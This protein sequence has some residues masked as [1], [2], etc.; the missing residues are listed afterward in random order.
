M[1]VRRVGSSSWVEANQLPSF[2][3]EAELERLLAS[4]P[5]LL[6]GRP[7]GIALVQQFHIPRVQGFFDLCGVTPDGSIYL[8]EC[9]LAGNPDMRRTIVG[10]LLAYAAGL[11][12]SSSEEFLS[13][14]ARAAGNSG[15]SWSSPQS[16]FELAPREERGE[17]DEPERLPE[18]LAENLKQGRFTLVFAVDRLT[19]ELGL[20]VD[21]LEAQMP[22]VRVC[23]LEMRYGQHENTEVLTPTLRGASFESAKVSSSYAAAT[24][25]VTWADAKVL[26]APSVQDAFTLLQS[27]AKVAGAEIWGARKSQPTLG[28]TYTVG[29]RSVNAW[30][31]SARPRKPGF[32][33]MWRWMHGAVPEERP[34]ALYAELR[35]LRVRRSGVGC[36]R[37]GTTST[38]STPR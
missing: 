18:R 12:G 13:S 17:D 31:M 27:S 4:S 14:F 28:A 32:G 23:A 8:I 25:D 10:Q 35:D 9:K 7:V 29:G 20:V 37:T 11:A 22:N 5:D 21:Y 16:C 34:A 24:T 1:F 38:T 19:D 3:L 30:L 15:R 2:G 6:P 26:L 36:R 33:I